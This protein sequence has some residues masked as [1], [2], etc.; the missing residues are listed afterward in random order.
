MDS[1]CDAWY[2]SSSY[3]TGLASPLLDSRLLSQIE[4]SCNKRLAV[5]CIEVVPPILRR[6]RHEPIFSDYSNHTKRL[7]SVIIARQKK[8]RPSLPTVEE[9]WKPYILFPVSF[10]YDG[11]V[12]ISKCWCLRDLRSQDV[13][14]IAEFGCVCVC[15]CICVRKV[16]V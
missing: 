13:Y 8:G 7:D 3:K 5:L 15:M 6:R 1:F 12:P 16:H 4:F 14:H 11:K 9:N 2:T 10:T